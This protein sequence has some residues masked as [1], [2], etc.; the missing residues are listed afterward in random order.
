MREKNHM[1]LRWE[2]I[3]IIV[4]KLEFFFDKKCNIVYYFLVII[5]IKCLIEKVMIFGLYRLLFGK[6]HTYT[7]KVI[8][9]RYKCHKHIRCV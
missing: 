2:S 3:L 9:G 1:L 8:M 7:D 4:K 5:F 6:L